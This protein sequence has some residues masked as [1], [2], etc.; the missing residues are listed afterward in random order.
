MTVSFPRGVSTPAAEGALPSIGAGA[1][2]FKIADAIQITNGRYFVPLDPAHPY[3]DYDIEYIAHSLSLQC[4]WMGGT[5]DLATGEPLLYS[6]AQHSVIVSDLVNMGRTKL[7]PKWDWEKDDS[8][9]FYGLMHDASEAYL[10]DI[11][12]PLK[13][14]LVG[15]YDYE[16]KLMDSIIAY[17]G[18]PMSS[19]I[20]EAVRR[21]D[22]AMIFW[23]RDKLIGIPVEPYGNEDQHPLSTIDEVVPDFYCWSPKEAKQRFLDKFAEIVTYDGNYV[24]LEYS[25]R[26]Y[27]I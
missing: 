10:C 15:Y 3:N 25:G 27:G 18:I 17:F 26:G 7:V 13:P 1:G 22:N 4:R 5:G 20:K 6:V 11:P 12:R 8:P 23:E 19:A 21:V 24:P 14:C 2:L 9:A 16:A